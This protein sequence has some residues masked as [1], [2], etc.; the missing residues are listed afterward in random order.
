API[1]ALESVELFAAAL[2]RP[3]DWRQDPAPFAEKSQL[4]IDS[5]A[6]RTVLGWSERFAGP[7]AVRAAAAWYAAWADGADPAALSR[8]MARHEPSLATAS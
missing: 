2:G 1:T 5:S 4:A 8:A 7:E 6:A 3:L